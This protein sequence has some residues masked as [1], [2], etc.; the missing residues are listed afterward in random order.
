MNAY[1]Q[2]KVERLIQRELST[3]FQQSEANL[4]PGTLVNVTVVRV[5]SDLSHAKVYLSIYNPNVQKEEIFNIID[6]HKKEIRHALAQR[7]R[8]KVRIIPELAFYI[9]D[10]YD[11]YKRIEELLKK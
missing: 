2:Q 6:I 9:D 8:N 4:Y 11:Y 7:I 10:S 3:I 5:S 1:R